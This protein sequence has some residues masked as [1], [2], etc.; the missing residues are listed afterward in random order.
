M[1]TQRETG[2]DE[3]RGITRGADNRERFVRVRTHIHTQ[4]YVCCACVRAR[5]RTCT[6]MLNYAAC[7][8]SGLFGGSQSLTGNPAAYAHR[9]AHTYKYT[10]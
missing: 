1:A 3:Y 8:F 2:R 9:N 6:P 10:G 7:I 5:A 4:T